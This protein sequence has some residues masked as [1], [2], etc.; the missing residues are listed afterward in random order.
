[1]IRGARDHDAVGI[2]AVYR[3]YV[4]ESAISFELDPPGAE[5]ICQRMLAAPR[6]PWFVAVRSDAVRSDAVRGDAVRG[7][8]VVG[9]AYASRHRERPAYRWSV[10]VTVY[11]LPAE[12]G[13]GT[14]RALYDTL[15]AAVTELG[16]VSAFAGITLPNEASVAL[17]EA[18][19]FRP[20]GVFAR[21]GFKQGRWHD[22]G[23]WQRTLRAAPA[24]P[25]EPLPWEQPESTEVTP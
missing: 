15:L 23:W 16:Y 22:V 4:L 5:Q 17:H 6:L 10:D 9:Y 18:L 24:I 1:M 19:G 8:V 14:G 25:R 12:R 11:L 13:R 2:A 3:P 21:A 7:D 20:V